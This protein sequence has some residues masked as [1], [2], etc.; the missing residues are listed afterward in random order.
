MNRRLTLNAERLVDLT[1]EDL[2]TVV[3][4][5]NSLLCLF[6]PP[7]SYHTCLD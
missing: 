5:R 1:P 4:A 3:G 2:A 6:P 7:G